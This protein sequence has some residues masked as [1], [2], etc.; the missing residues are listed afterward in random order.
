MEKA[1]IYKAYETKLVNEMTH[2]RNAVLNAVNNAFRKKN[3]K[4][5][6]LYKKKQAKA[7]KEYNHNAIQVI[8]EIEEKEGKSW[9]DRIYKESGL[10]KPERKVGD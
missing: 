7:D 9:V 1:F 2:I 4:F 10:K 5:I 3:K 6:D 8:H